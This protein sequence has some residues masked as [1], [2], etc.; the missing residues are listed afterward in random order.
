M[1]YP[2]PP[3]H[4][5]ADYFIRILATPHGFED[6]SKSVVKKICDNFSVSDYAKEVDVIVQYE[7]HMGRAGTVSLARIVS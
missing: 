2:C 6:N 4:N 5:P 3:A 7:F 1:G